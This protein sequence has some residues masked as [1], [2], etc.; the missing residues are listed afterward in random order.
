ELP[1]IAAAVLHDERA[2]LDHEL[3]QRRDAGYPPYTRLAAVLFSGRIEKEVEAMAERLAE[4][5]RPSAEARGVRVLGPAPQALTRLKNQ[6][7][8]HFLLK[9]S[10]AP[11]LRELLEAALAASEADKARK[12]VRV[13]VD[14][15]PV[16][17]L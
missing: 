5:I 16:E 8:W 4:A 11:A 17:V 6:Y 13:I 15:D 2:F 12:S 10:A 14:V 3:A 7:R 1:A 9:A